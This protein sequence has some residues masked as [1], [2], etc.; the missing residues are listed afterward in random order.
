MSF[1]AKTKDP[2][3]KLDYKFDWAPLTNNRKNAL[4]DWLQT[5]ETILSYVISADSG[6][7]VDSDAKGDSDTSVVVWLSG[8]AN[9]TDYNVS[10]KITTSDGRVD[11][12]TMTIKV[13]QK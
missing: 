11:E 6:I 7:T 12:R 1:P 9:G 2:D 4:S 10:C 13:R 8:G 5:G 3:A